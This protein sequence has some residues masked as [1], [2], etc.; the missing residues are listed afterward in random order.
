MTEK[1]EP[2]Y[3]KTSYR[4]YIVLRLGNSVMAENILSSDLWWVNRG[5]D[6]DKKYVYFIQMVILFSGN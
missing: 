6:T 1:N 2:I 4:I 5:C 3:E